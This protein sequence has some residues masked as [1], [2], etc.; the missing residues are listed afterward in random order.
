MHG[1][2]KRRK[3][4]TGAET[5]ECKA[6]AVVPNLKTRTSLETISLL[7]ARGEGGPDDVHASDQA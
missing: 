2:S 4:I 1:Q 5:V 6:P 7:H 3:K